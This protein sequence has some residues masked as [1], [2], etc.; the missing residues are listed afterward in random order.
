MKTTVCLGQPSW[1]FASNKTEAAI[2]QLGGQ[3]APVSFRLPQGV[4]EPFSVAPWAE[5]PATSKL[6]PLLRALRGDF[7]CTPFGGNETPYRGESHPPHGETA[8]AVWKFESLGNVEDKTT[9]HLSLAPTIRPGRVDKFIQLRENETT[10]YCRHIISGMSGR[11]PVGHHAILKFPLE[12]ES[13]NLS[14][15]KIRFA[16]VC[17]TAFENPEQGGYSSL[18]PGA[19]FSRME[20]VPKADGSHADLSRYPTGRGFDNLVMLVHEARPD[21]AWSAVTFP[22]QRYVWFALK[23]PR[24]LRNTILWMSNGGRHY[25]PWSGRHVNILGVEDVTA[26]FHYGLAESVRSNPVNRRGFATSV[27][28]PK[29]KPFTVNYIMAVAEIPRGFEKVQAIEAGDG[30]VTLISTGNHRV[31][32]PMDT[33]F[34]GETALE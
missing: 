18:K 25:A 9:L 26:Y 13:G 23:D 4:V 8:N 34:L 20:R 32:V 7:F 27:L 11:L 5:E 1:Q 16:Q 6:V 29:N 30:H 22:Q 10:L 33:G 19:E 12:A 31:L 15:S 24:V 3:L 17:P 14:T 2:T 28:I 21:F